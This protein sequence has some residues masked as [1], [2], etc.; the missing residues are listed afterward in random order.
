MTN[1]MEETTY[2][3]QG[4]KRTVRRSRDPEGDALDAVTVALLAYPLHA[5]EDFAFDDADI[6][7]WKT[8]AGQMHDD[9]MGIAKAIREKDTDTARDLYSNATR[10]CAACHKKFREE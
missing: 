3:Y 8:Y 1:L 6:A 9:F 2:L 7:S 5:N 10:S 4:L